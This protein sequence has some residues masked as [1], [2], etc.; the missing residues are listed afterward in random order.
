MDW[1]ALCKQEMHSLKTRIVLSITHYLFQTSIPNQKDLQNLNIVSLSSF[2]SCSI[3]QLA[4]KSEHMDVR[5]LL[6]AKVG[7]GDT[8]LWTIH[9]L[10]RCVCR[11]TGKFRAFAHPG[12]YL[13]WSLIQQNWMLLRRGK[14]F[15][16]M[17]WE[18]ISVTPVG[19][20]DIVV[21]RMLC[22]EGQREVLS[23]ARTF[24]C[25]ESAK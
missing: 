7:G 24:V 2:K 15:R 25:L 16:E 1:I 6:F 12:K 18:M 9:I 14:T 21:S 17:V 8:A 11:L 13:K 19:E 20:P 22:P 4:L 3:H 23:F 10:P 5:Y